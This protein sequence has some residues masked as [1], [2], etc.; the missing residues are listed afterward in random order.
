MTYPP[1]A[2][3]EKLFRQRYKKAPSFLSIHMGIKADALAPGSGEPGE[4]GHAE[5]RLGGELP[6]GPEGIPSGQEAQWT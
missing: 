2:P 1:P 6:V 3:A 5:T 4:W